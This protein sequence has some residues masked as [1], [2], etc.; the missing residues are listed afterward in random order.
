VLEG[1][2]RKSGDRL[3]ITT[4]L[5]R[6]SDSSQLWAQTY[7]RKLDDVFAVQEE[8]AATIVGQLKIKL[9]GA[10]PAPSKTDP[11]AFALFLQAREI[12]RQNTGAAMDR[13]NALYQQALAIVQRMSPRGMGWPVTTAHRS[14]SLCDL[15]TMVFA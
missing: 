6:S 5:I 10:A 7:E 1:S 13:S 9:L 2:V 15:P 4:Q 11:G 8:I 3:R 12:R 14:T